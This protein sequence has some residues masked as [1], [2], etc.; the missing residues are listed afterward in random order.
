MAKKL[1]VI[2]DDVSVAKQLRWGLGKEY[3][4]T[5]A[6]DTK[7]AK[8][9]L[10]SGI[11]PVVTLDLGLPP[12]P[13]SP[14][15]GLALLQ[16]IPTL[17]PHAQVIVITG[18]SEEENA[19]TAIARGAGDFCEKPIDLNLLRVIISRA[20][21]RYRLEAAHRERQQ[22]TLPKG[23]LC[24]MLG[25]SATMNTVFDHLTHASTT[26]Y[27]VL[28]T[29]NTGTGKELAARAIHTLGPKAHA[30]FVIIN[31]GAIPSNLL[32]SELFGHE[33][34][35]FTGASC[36]KIGKLERAN[37]GTVFLDEIGELP[38]SMQVKILRFI[39]ESTIER[40]GGTTTLTLDV[41]ILAA[42]NIH[43]KAAVNK[44][45]FRT[46]LF[47]RLNVIPLKIPDLC[48]RGS[49]ISLL[50]HH[51]LQEESKKLHRGPASF[52]QAA[53]EA[54]SAHHWPGNVRELQN[55]IRRALGT[56]TEKMIT[57]VDLGLE[58]IKTDIEGSRVPTLKGARATAEKKAI[59]KALALSDNNITQAAKL[60]EISRPTLHDLLK[61][62]G[63]QI[64]KSDAI[65]PA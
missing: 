43:L 28:I 31:C 36:R 44:G 18:N 62:H 51:F 34:G 2:E 52:T 24:G 3:E 35:A 63:I 21:N 47:Y 23:A 17:A 29:G 48:E 22:Q 9:L 60:I 45:T 33:K 64:H 32:E 53:M 5:I 50:A 65:E 59:Y 39:Q 25:A 19:I 37:H 26:D 41:R 58:T 6:P 11:F 42:T 12:S 4:I 27:P 20:F 54:L 8:A 46:D 61:K 30:P 7:K 55:C 14:R 38:L 10:A 57:P 1:L 56:T 15:Y 16:E 13:E 49:D 40:L